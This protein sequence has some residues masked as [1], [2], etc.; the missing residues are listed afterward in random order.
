MR[1]RVIKLW[2]DFYSLYQKICTKD[3]TNE[4]PKTIHNKANEWINLFISLGAKQL[5]YTKARVTP[6]MHFPAYYLPG[7]I[8]NYGFLMQFSR[9]QVKKNDDAKCIY[10]QKSNRWDAARDILL[11]ESWKKALAHHERVKWKY[12]KKNM[13]WWNEK[14]VDSRK[15]RK[16]TKTG[17]EVN[18]TANGE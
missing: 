8:Q 17:D 14:I 11:W 18:E 12:E 2:K 1:A 3:V 6:Y 10:Y 13:E 5:G 9:Q 7:F 4:L 16:S 15:K